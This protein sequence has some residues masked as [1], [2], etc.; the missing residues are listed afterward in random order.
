MLRS[1]KEERQEL[2]KKNKAKGKS[3]IKTLANGAKGLQI[4]IMV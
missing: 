2:N 1:P 3:T 4:Q